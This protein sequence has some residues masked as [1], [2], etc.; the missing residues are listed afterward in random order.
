VPSTF[1]FPDVEPTYEFDRDCLAFPALADGK[2]VTCL[3]TVEFL[4]ARFGAR[5][6]SEQAMRQAYRE[7]K[8]E[9]QAIA[10]DH[11]EKGWIDEE[12]RIFLTTRYTRLTVK[13]TERLLQWPLGRA[14]A[15]VAYRLLLELIGPRA[16]EVSVEWDREDHAEDLDRMRATI[17]DPSTSTTEVLHFSASDKDDTSGLR[18]HLATAWGSVLRMRSR[19]LILKSG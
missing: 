13:F 7:H 19:N 12:S 17:F 16:G 3:V 11:I 6:P 2:A 1:V 18:A 14:T 15:D 9:I 8:E 5:E 10:R 4:M